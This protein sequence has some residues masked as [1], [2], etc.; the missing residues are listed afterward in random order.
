MKKLAIIGAT[1]MLG[2]P[3]TIALL[4]AGYELTVLARNPEKARQLWGDK[5]NILQGDV[6]NITDLQ[7]LLHNQEGLYINLSVLPTSSEKDFQPEREGMENIITAAK[8]AGIRRIAYL[9]SIV[10]RYQG[11]NGFHWWVFDIKNKAVEMI[12]KSG[13]PY[14]IFYASNFM[15]NFERGNYRQG[16]RIL[17]AGT[18]KYPMY[19][20]AASD[21]AK[22]V[23]EAFKNDGHTSFN[24]DVQGPEAFTADEAA[25]AFVKGYVKGKLNISKAPVG[26]I[27]FLGNFSQ[28]MNY[29]AHILQ[30]LNNYP[31]SFTSQVTWQHL[32]EPAITLAAF[33]RQ[34]E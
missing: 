5:V 9:S 25:A 22:Q 7:E 16:K 19:F 33:A 1:G 27:K 26:L 34:A 24:Y 23:A 12:K 31:E 14:T 15:D 17:L 20:I 11:L 4:Q 2:Q 21:Y 29:G 30:A 8:Q 6:K 13:I 28:K 10:Q 32:G 18:S 3:V